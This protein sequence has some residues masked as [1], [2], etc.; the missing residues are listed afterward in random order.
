MKKII[1][2]IAFTLLVSQSEQPYPPLDLVSIPTAGTMSKGAFT[3]EML[4]QK[5][6]GLLPKLAIGLTHHFTLG[7]SFGV[8]NF[9]GDEKPSINRPTPEV[10]LKYRMYEETTSKPAFVVGLNTQG[11]GYFHEF[12][13]STETDLLNRYDQKALGI[14]LVASKNWNVFGN[15][16]VHL[17]VSHNVRKNYDGD[18][19]Y[20]FFFG[21]DKELNRSFSLLLEYDSAFN[22]NNLN[23]SDITFGK[24]FGY[25]NAGVR[26]TIAQ[27]LMIELNLNNINQNT[28]AKYTN[29]EVKIMYS[30]TF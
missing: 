4:L 8:Q 16:G 26:W 30:E 6:G 11:R 19:D 2:V 3:L 7:M 15:L 13:D 17:G 14:Y 9:I 5:D 12:S 20:N 28:D 29:R 27:N 22:D 23:I 21:V 18:D 1:L 10:Q 24:G 25:L